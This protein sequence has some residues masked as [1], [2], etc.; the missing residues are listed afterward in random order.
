MTS[1]VCDPHAHNY[2]VCL[3]CC[4]INVPKLAISLKGVER[5]LLPVKRDDAAL[6]PTLSA[7]RFVCVVR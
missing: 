3:S 6:K 4:H 7:V 1:H 5:L 2:V